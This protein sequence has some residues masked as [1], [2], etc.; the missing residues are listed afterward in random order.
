M[1]KKLVILLLA[2]ALPGLIFLF[3]KLFGNNQFDIPV[4]YKNGVEDSITCKNFQKGQYI[5]E[6]TMLTSVSWNK[7]AALLI[8]DVSL[9]ER[10]ELTRTLADVSSN[11]LQI[12]NL[13][14]NKV[15]QL[16]EVKRCNL[17]LKDPWNA[18]LMDKQKRIRGY[19]SLKSR[20]E[21]D[22][23]DVEVEILLKK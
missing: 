8:S 12:I 20:E 14:S 11:E 21:L 15:K 23:L 4:F 5:L 3:L 18:V 13:D 10:K 7:G 1:N 16:D 22:R 6:D 19:Y 9:N 17:F 2:L